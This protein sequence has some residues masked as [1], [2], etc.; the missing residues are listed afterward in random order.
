VSSGS[1]AGL[2]H[3]NGNSAGRPTPPARFSRGLFSGG[4]SWLPPAPLCWFVQFSQV[5]AA[6]FVLR[7]RRRRSR[8]RGCK[9]GLSHSF[10]KGNHFGHQSVGSCFEPFPVNAVCRPGTSDAYLICGYPF[11]RSEAEPS[12]RGQSSRNCPFDSGELRLRERCMRE[13]L[14]IKSRLKIGQADITR[15]SVAADRCP[16]RTT[17]IGAIDQKASNASGAHLSEGYLLRSGDGGHAPSSRRLQ[18]E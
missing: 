10:P 16:V 5:M 2:L 12:I 15:P 11:P 3:P 14:Q 17:I 1:R 6:A 18:W 7:S 8:L 4:G 9:F 13:V